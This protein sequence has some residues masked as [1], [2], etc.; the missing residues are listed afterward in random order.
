LIPNSGP[1]IT[2]A[3]LDAMH[4]AVSKGWL[5]A[6]PINNQFEKALG[7]FTGHSYVH[8]CNSGSSA[9]LLAVAA[10]V[11]SGFWK[12]GDEIITAACAFPTTVNPLLLYGLV[13]VFVDVELSTLNVS[14]E[15]INKA[16]TPKTKGVML[17]H[18]LGNPYELTL[19][20]DIYLIEDC[21]DAL[22]ATV[23]GVHVGHIG[24]IATC[25][26]FP[27]HHITTGEGG[28]VFTN[29]RDL[30]SVVESVRDWGRD[31]WCEPGKE[32]TCGKRFDWNWESLPHGFDHK[33]TYSRL[34]YNLKTTE[35]SSACGLV[36][37]G[38]VEEFIRQRRENHAYLAQRL[39]ALEDISI[40]RYSEGASPFGFP[41]TLKEEG[42]RS[43]LQQYLRQEGIDSRLIFSGNLTKQP[44]MKGRNF[45]VVGDLENTDKIMNDSLWIG[46]HP[47]LTV[48]QLGYMA[49]KV[50][51]FFGSF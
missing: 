48:D 28:A 10:L 31:C 29:S 32:N 5:T 14:Q 41:F 7:A 30:A 36:Q 19:P 46:C 8:T 21:C 20:D 43:N 17:A 42:M 11:E 39:S 50:E 37:L 26:F 16:V 51:A 44:Y 38:R 23:G 1:S 25:S 13:P 9:N 3:E 4:K 40:P 49:S 27:A 24:R 47:S 2:E 22:G 34:G 12:K 6:G 15:T 33:Y 18:T 45:R 35:V